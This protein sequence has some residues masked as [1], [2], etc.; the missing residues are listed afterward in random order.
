MRWCWHLPMH[1]MLIRHGHKVMP[2]PLSSGEKVA[3]AMLAS[4]C[5]GCHS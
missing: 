5:L 3:A 4:L 2:E 1:S